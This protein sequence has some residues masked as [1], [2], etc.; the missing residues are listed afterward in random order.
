[1]EARPILTS[2]MFI[3]KYMPYVPPVAVIVDQANEQG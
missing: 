2:L 1:M 3:H